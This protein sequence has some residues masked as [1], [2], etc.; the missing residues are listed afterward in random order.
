[1]DTGRL[2]AWWSFRQGLDGR[3]NGK[4]P[5]E[6]LAETGWARSVG[7]AGPYLTQVRRT[8]QFVRSELGDARSFS[9]DSPKSRTLRIQALR[10]G[11]F[12]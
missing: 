10:A 2:R 11:A 7:G 3:L 8:Q 4:S 1:M 5:A 9:L 12:S 6:V